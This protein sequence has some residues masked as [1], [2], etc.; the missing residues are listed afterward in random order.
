MTQWLSLNAIVLIIRTNM[1]TDL[2]CSSPEKSPS[3]CSM[4][5][6]NQTGIGDISQT[7][8]GQI[9]RKANKKAATKSNETSKTQEGNKTKDVLTNENIDKGIDTKEAEL[10]TVDNA[11]ESKLAENT[12]YDS[13]QSEIARADEASS[14]GNECCLE[15][16]SPQKRREKRQKRKKRKSLMEI[17]FV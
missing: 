14:S 8:E 12:R 15:D 16:C 5:S 3:Y 10:D 11:C 1:I 6:A 9:A 4:N 2:G 13:I 7:N 17:L